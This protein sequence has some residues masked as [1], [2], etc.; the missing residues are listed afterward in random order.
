[1]TSFWIPLGASSDS[2]RIQPWASPEVILVA[3]SA[4]SVRLVGGAV[5]GLGQQVVVGEHRVDEV[6]HRD[7][8]RLAVDLDLAGQLR[9]VVA[10]LG[11]DR[12]QVGDRALVGEVA[13]QSAVEPDDVRHGAGSRAGDHLLLGRGV[14]TGQEVDRDAGVLGLELVHQLAE[15]AV[16][17]SGSHHCENSR[18]TSPPGRRRR[19]SWT[20]RPGACRERECCD[21]GECNEASYVSA[22]AH[23]SPIL[24]ICRLVRLSAHFCVFPPT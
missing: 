3:A 12:G 17:G 11:H 8:V 19:P 4:N 7:H 18:V 2:G 10:R 20:R 16:G 15:R 24:G 14:R 1:M 13:D 6:H 9:L 22:L 21:T 23:D 5:A